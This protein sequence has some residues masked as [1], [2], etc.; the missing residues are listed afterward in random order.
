MPRPT[1]SF[2]QIIDATPHQAK[3]TAQTYVQT[4][5]PIW[6]H[7]LNDGDSRTYEPVLGEECHYAKVLD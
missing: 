5:Y 3:S 7:S 4:N 1:L 6:C 2:L